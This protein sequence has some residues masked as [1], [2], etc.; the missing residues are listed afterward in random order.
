MI[1]PINNYVFFTVSKEFE[2]ELR[3]KSGLILHVATQAE[4]GKFNRI[5]GEVIAVPGKLTSD[6]NLYQKNVYFP[7]PKPS[8]SGEMVATLAK[9]G[10]ELTGREYEC[11]PYEREYTNLSDITM[12][13][14]VDDQIYFHFNT[15]DEEN[16]YT[17]EDGRKIYKVRYDQI[18]CA[19]RKAWDIDID[20][21]ELFGKPKEV[22]DVFIRDTENAIWDRLKK[23][24]KIRRLPST[25]I[26]IGGHVLVQSVLQQGMV[27]T[28]IENRKVIGKITPGGIM[29]DIG[30][31]TEDLDDVVFEGIIKHI[32]APIKGEE[33]LDVKPGDKVVCLPNANWVNVINGQ[34]YF[35]MKQRD[36]IAKIE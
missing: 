7:E 24:G 25:I 6:I 18:I 3:L 26:M 13:V 9:V 10:H 14:E 21:I 12:E 30:K 22:I 17:L 8:Y 5:Y 35:V 33:E 34:E 29:H 11:S 36:L 23:E 20:A 2:N 28:V 19:V 32:G 16:K 31:A 15:I 1:R 4:H 27:E